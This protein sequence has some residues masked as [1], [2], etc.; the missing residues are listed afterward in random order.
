MGF[1]DKDNITTKKT[2][3]KIHPKLKTVMKRLEPLRWSGGASK[4]IND[5]VNRSL[6][7]YERWWA[8]LLQYKIKASRPARLR[9][10]MIPQFE[11]PAEYIAH[12]FERVNRYIIYNRQFGNSLSDSIWFDDHGWHE[13]YCCGLS[14]EWSGDCR[15]WYQLRRILDESRKEKK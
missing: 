3:T 14:E 10:Y 4:Q 6:W 12:W 2:K 8:R 7:N 9:E 1:F 13:N 11:G 5:I 15:L